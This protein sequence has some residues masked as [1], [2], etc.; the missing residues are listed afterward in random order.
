MTPRASGDGP[1][2]PVPASRPPLQTT[3]RASG[4]SPPTPVP[5][6]RPP[7]Q[8]TVRG[9]RGFTLL[10]VLIALA[11]VG[12]LL[13]VAFG[14]LRVG[15]AA[16]RQ[17]EDRAEAHQHARGVALLLARAVSGAYPYRASAGQA[18]EPVV[19]FRGGEDRLEFVTQTPPLPAATPIAFTA[20]VL[21]IDSGDE[22]GLVV[23]QRV[24]PNRDPFTEA[25]VALRD[26]S[27][28][29]LSFRYL[30]ESGAWRESWDGES[31]RATPLAV[32]ITV[33]AEL[34]G[35]IETF[36]ALTVSLRPTPP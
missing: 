30:D 23:R 31:E 19:L 35:R 7:L 34:H 21:A 13:A 20:V 1:P 17:G 2:T 12:A 27:V 29:M 28:T 3:P 26:A 33:E 5:A 18:P 36:P 11:I 10:E 24:L 15:L 16:W 32:R 25:A 14:G 22:P 6:S 8:T 9:H 4:D